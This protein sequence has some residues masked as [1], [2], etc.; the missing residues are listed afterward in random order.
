M[1]HGEVGRLH[2]GGSSR[3]EESLGDVFKHVWH[4]FIDASPVGLAVDPLAA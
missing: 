1:G 2:F 4:V 3:A